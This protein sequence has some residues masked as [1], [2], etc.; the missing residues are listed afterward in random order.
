[1]K[2]S[3]FGLK[4]SVLATLIASGQVFAQN[5]PDEINHPQYLKIYQNLEQVLNQKIADF[6][7]LSEQRA[8]ILK[9]ISQMEKDQAEIPSRNNELRRAIEM[10]RIEI[11][12]LDSEIQGL[13]GVLSKIIE[14][15]RRMENIISQLQRDINTESNRNSQI[16]MSRNQASQELAQISSRLQREINEENQSL[17]VL[18][19]LTGETNASIQR[20]E[21]LERERIQ[22]VRNAEKFKSEIIQTRNAVIQNSNNLILKKNQLNTSQAKL[23]TI[24]A[25]LNREEAKLAQIDS[26]LAP[27]KDKLN[28]LK[29]E[30]ARLSPEI[31][32]LQNENRSLDQKIRSNET[33][34]NSL[35]VTP[36]ITRRDFLEN[37]ISGVKSQIKVNTEAQTA[38][39]EKIEPVMDEIRNLNLKMQQ[40]LRDRNLPEAAR[41]KNQ[42]DELLK[43]IL[44]D[45]NQITRLQ[46]ESEH[47]AK[48]ISARQ[49][50]INCLNASIANAETQIGNL[51]NEIESSKVK[52]SENEK[53][54]AELSS[55]NAELGQQISSLDSEI[56]VIESERAPTAQKVSSLKQQESQIL[57]EVNSLTSEIQKLESDNQ[58]LTA[59]VTEMEKFIAELPENLRRMDAHVR[60][61]SQKIMDLRAQIDREER[62]LVRIRQNR[63]TI[64]A[65]VN[66]AQSVLDQINRD[67]NDSERLLANLTSR[68]NEESSNRDALVR[69]NQDSINKL[70]N[71]KTS[72]SR[73][74]SEVS[75]ASNE[76]RINEEDLATINRELPKLRASVEVLNPKIQAAEKAKVLAQ[77]NADNANNQYLS[78]LTLFQKYLVEAQTL[79]SEKGV[80]GTQDGN[81]SGKI[82]ASLRAN[83]LGSENASTHAKWDAL[84]R[85]YVRGEVSGYQNGYDIGLS[86]SQDASRGDEDGR[87]AGSRRAK[88][89]ANMILKPEKY[90]EEFERRLKEDE[91]I[92]KKLILAKLVQQDISTLS[93]MS[94]EALEEIPELTNDELKQSSIILTSLD[95]LISQSEIEIKDVLDLRK[96]LTDP[97]NVYL[98]PNAGE[99]AN[100]VNCSAVYKGIREFIN[101]C[102]DSYSNRYE[103]LY[104]LAHEDSF[105]KNYSANFQDQVK[106]V[107]EAE[108]NR[109][110][111]IYLKEASKVSQE[112]GIS[113]GKKDIYQQSFTRAE[114]NAYALA[115]PSETNRVEIEANQL[116]QDHLNQNAALTLKSKPKL[117][118][119]DSAGLAPGVDADLSLLIK[120][121]GSKISNG[122]SILKITEASSSLSF[123]RKES[124][125]PSIAPRSNSDLSLLKVKISDDSLPGSN[126]VLAGEIT[127]PGN[128]YRSSRVES[129]RIET[130][131]KVNPALDSGIEFDNT[132]KVSGL[133]GTKKHDINLKI[134]PKFSGVDQGYEFN[135]EEVGSQFVSITSNPSMTEILGRSVEKKVRFTYKLDKAARGKTV[136]LKL[137]IKNGGKIV[138]QSNLE[139][140]P[141]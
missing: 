81:K 30:L 129:F 124:P 16:Q 5:L 22:A 82:D 24:K 10:K 107:F 50:E 97:K 27:K 38:L 96:K 78:R 108:L 9:S 132:P 3:A 137:T 18:N 133:F 99:N 40:A 20:R 19:R 13:E 35:N 11:S 31:S 21:E 57:A 1:M 139:I 48:S 58:K 84:R 135:L 23:P 88:D 119:N 89:Y 37:E 79:G 17:Q 59:R 73:I 83:K 45:K 64:Q 118:T 113:N 138:T 25:D 98:A 126:V 90:N 91:T 117:N 67:L 14:D 105:N 71:L 61:L 41:L 76:V 4:V 32:R 131:L 104:K 68:L 112:V 116:V 72:R 95:S 115:L 106:N 70:S 54:I 141:E 2:P 75:N 60:Q 136:S 15:L 77:S 121:I 125:I 134:K 120:N 29:A 102:K 123:D 114:N 122:E 92:L 47:L 63:M 52:I 28:K 130:I 140:K 49:S 46:K 94:R 34:I 42:I 127:H 44:S 51:R 86:S 55:A 7:E 128:H 6:N 85:G 74:E 109:L 12:R 53:K 39:E 36:M 56:K 33:R 110:Y 69:Y 26:V 103:T 93:S 8:V 87:M 111:P 100:N 80:I 101:A 62:L 66:R 43:S 65:D